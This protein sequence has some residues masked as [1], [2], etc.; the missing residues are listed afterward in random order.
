MHNQIKPTYLKI[1]E[2]GAYKYIYIKIKG[3]KIQDTVTFIKQEFNKIAADM[4]FFY[5]FMDEEIAKKY[6]NEKRYGNMFSF[7]SFFAI[8]IACSGLFGL[9]S[10]AIARRTKEISIRKILGASVSNIMKSINKEFL[11]LVIFGNIFAWPCAYLAAKYWLQNFAYQIVISPVPFL[12]AGIITFVI[13]FITI[14]VKL[15]RA[16]ATNPVDSLRCD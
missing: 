5:T 13:A 15:S 14:A 9:T 3:D 16:A 11:F 7:V 2:N 10:L 6:E 8:L 4:P 1:S 12:V